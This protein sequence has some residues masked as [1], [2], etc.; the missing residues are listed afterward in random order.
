[1]I[2]KSSSTSASQFLF[3]IERLKPFSQG[4]SVRIV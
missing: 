3:Y 1:V 2:G 4:T